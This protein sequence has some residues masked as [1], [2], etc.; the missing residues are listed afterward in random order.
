MFLT[1]TE[2]EMTIHSFIEYGTGAP[3]VHITFSYDTEARTMTKTTRRGR[4]RATVYETVSL[5]DAQIRSL[6]LLASDN[7]MAAA[8]I[9]GE[10][11]GPSDLDDYYA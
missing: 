11:E 7:Q 1:I 3:L 5:T 9:F 10:A 4:G 8:S 2:I 6:N